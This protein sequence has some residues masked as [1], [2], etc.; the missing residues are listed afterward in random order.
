MGDNAH[1]SGETSRG[2]WPR[3]KA[4]LL[5]VHRWLAL[6]F[7][8]IFV[9]IL[10]SGAILAFKPIADDM[11]ARAGRP[12][13]ER[14][15]LARLVTV[16]DKADPQG[17][18]RSVTLSGDSRTV[19]IRPAGGAAPVTLDLATGERTEGTIPRPDIFEFAKDL[20]RTLLTGVGIFATLATYAM[21]V[22]IVLGP[23]LAWPRPANTLAGWH[24]GIGWFLLP[25]VLLTPITAVLLLLHI[26]GPPPPPV[27]PAERTISLARAL[28]QAAGQVDL[29]RLRSAQTFRGGN[30]RI[31]AAGP[32]G[33][34]AYVVT[35]NRVSLL[36]G[37]G[38][39]RELHEGTW[40]GAWSGLINLVSV[41]ALTGLTGTGTVAWLRRWRHG[42]RSTGD[43][44]ADILVTYA[45]Q[46][47]TASRLAEATADVLRAGRAKVTS[48][49]L[50]GVDPTTLGHFRRVLLIV[51]TTG[52]GYVPE[53]GRAFVRKLSKANLS[54]VSFSL[55]ALGDSRYANFCGGGEE[56]RTA[57]LAAGAAESV[58]MVRA[59]REP[60][61]SWR[62]WLQR[63]SAQ[64]GIAAGDV[65]SPE[66]DR[67]I[68]LSLV[69][70]TQLNDPGDRETNEAWSLVFESTLPL[71]YR[72]GDLVL[73][74]PGDGE[75]ERPYSI[76]S[77]PLESN[78][79]LL[80]TVGLKVWQD[81]AGGEHVGKASGLLCRKLVIGDVIE[82]KLRRHPTFNPPEDNLPVIMVA[83]GCG[84]APFVGFLTEHALAQRTSPTWL[85]F[86]NRKRAADFFYRDRLEQWLRS[87]QLSRL[88]TAFSRDPDDGAYVQDRL[89]EA[90]A[91][92]LD[93]LNRGGVF[94]LCGR[95]STVGVGVNAALT[96]IL[97]K[98]A[99]LS[100]F[101]A[102]RQLQLWEAEGKIRRDVYDD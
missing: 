100:A 16:L 13:G 49:S 82:A 48:K 38:L 3:A 46:T 36:A 62:E 14:V 73:I 40:A 31:I 23:L 45:S 61:G 72:P 55:L 52:E 92:V 4:G 28:Q 80:L 97:V 77:S 81:E 99:S 88:D 59:D 76:G 24:M 95:L 27:L 96:E 78:R 85:V 32:E 54:G 68:A 70:R 42:R 75:P 6:V 93:W 17:I 21:V 67:G 20:H 74:S 43:V 15:D 51:S 39:V 30:W 1:I 22:I 25:F 47:G 79:R 102:E 37:P 53:Q 10:L 58:P 89:V 65:K 71:D 101:D 8:P 57:L 63:V 60:E 26:G 90:G 19:T 2:V 56:V 64:L 86:G 34:L 98:T 18:A 66:R 91:E 94:Y 50:A 44:G 33:P 5:L 29:T 9:V 35:T 7:A 83:A 12:S 84:I 11:S 69:E 41:I 87:G